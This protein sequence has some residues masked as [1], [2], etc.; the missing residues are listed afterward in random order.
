MLPLLPP[1]FVPP[2]AFAAGAP[3]ACAA[4]AA[5][6]AAA[7]A[8]FAVGE[9]AIPAFGA[10]S[11]LG[12]PSAGEIAYVDPSL[13]WWPPPPEACRSPP[14]MHHPGLVT[15]LD[16]ASELG[17]KTEV[18][19]RALRSLRLQALSVLP[20]MVQAYE[21]GQVSSVEQLTVFAS[22]VRQAKCALHEIEHR[23]HQEMQTRGL[24]TLVSPLGAPPGH[25]Q[26][27]Q[28]PLPKPEPPPQ[29]PLTAPQP[30]LPKE[31]QPHRPQQQQPPPHP[32]GQRQQPPRAQQ[33]P[34]S[35]SGRQPP[36]AGDD[37]ERRAP[38]FEP[39]PPP[40][41]RS[42]SLPSTGHDQEVQRKA[43]RGRQGRVTFSDVRGVESL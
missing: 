26:P 6:V 23:V 29:R 18:V 42:S 27:Q 36:A 17:R 8:G 2:M 19:L 24:E 10:W 20:S 41:R 25:Q 35:Q 22:L 16:D 37:E 30:Q 28:P 1:P 38:V 33:Q 31:P 12:A 3:T 39:N 43:P 13:H 11:P 34:V 15:G 21:T 14:P 9:W 32:H 40:P 4:S 7:N 5:A